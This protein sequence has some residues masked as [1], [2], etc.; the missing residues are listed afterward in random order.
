MFARFPEFVSR[1]GNGARQ[2]LGAAAGRLRTGSA[3]G[4]LGAAGRIAGTMAA[5]LL[6]AG[7]TVCAIACP[8]PQLISAVALEIG[9]F[10]FLVYWRHRRRPAARD[11]T[12]WQAARQW[13][14]RRC[15]WLF[16]ACSAAE[17]TGALIAI[18]VALALMVEFTGFFLAF[19]GQETAAR[20]LSIS[21]PVSR[22]LTGHP[23]HSLEFL[24]GAYADAGNYKRAH[25]LYETLASIR[26]ASLPADDEL[27]PAI[28][29]DIGMLY[30]RE[31][32]YAQAET[33]FRR[34]LSMAARAQAD[35]MAGRLLTGLANALREEGRY[36]DAEDFYRQAIAMRGQRFGTGS[37]KV[38]E[39]LR[40]YAIC[41]D[42]S[43]HV[44]EAVA[45]R[46]RVAQIT[47]SH[48]RGGH[49]A[50]PAELVAAGGILTLVFSLL[51]F[52]GDTI[53]VGVTHFFLQRKAASQKLS[54][55]ETELLALLCARPPSSKP[56]TAKA[57]GMPDG[58][59]DRVPWSCIMRD[60]GGKKFR[61]NSF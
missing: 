58:G 44:S 51:A 5:G 17:K 26:A 40:E 27:V 19:C 3:S 47:A 15:R 53:L 12:R 54:A 31:K 34:S 8:S 22:Y 45:C 48:K 55:E 29:T 30:M 38:A 1:A 24:A 57:D 7:F 33:A 14:R 37:L 39:S 56:V 23:A 20:S 60:W 36:A 42:R 52:A 6:V 2:L 18:G 9:G 59:H 4:N 41:L 43:G 46:A 32:R 50:I 11:Q 13:W 21:A 25:P 35:L 49:A 28:W 10:F 16:V 61:G